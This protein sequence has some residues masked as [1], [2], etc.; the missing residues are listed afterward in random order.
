VGNLKHLIMEGLQ[1]DNGSEGLDLFHAVYHDVEKKSPGFQEIHQ[2]SHLGGG[3]APPDQ[4]QTT[5]GLEVKIG[6]AAMIVKQVNR[7]FSTDRQTLDSCSS[8]W[9]TSRA[10]KRR[11]RYESSS[12]QWGGEC[13]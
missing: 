10:K 4:Q 8:A 1:A 2:Q 9:A 12:N 5:G 6:S 11:T 3:Q 7:L 13:I